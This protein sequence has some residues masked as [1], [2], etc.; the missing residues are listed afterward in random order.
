VVAGQDIGVG[1]WRFLDAFTVPGREAAL[2]QIERFQSDGKTAVVVARFAEP[3]TAHVLGVIAVA[4]VLR[5]DAAQAVRELKAVGVERVVM[6]TGDHATVARAIGQQA[7]VDEVFADL[8]PED[9]LRII[10]ELREQSGPV[11]M[12]GDGVNDAPAL[13][14]ATIGIAMGAAGTD[15][16]LETADIVLMADDLR[17]IPPHAPL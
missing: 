7:G 12:V 5:R 6:L 17:N 8:L 4:D 2:Q 16:A 1:S 11:A 15:V 13:A 9:K 10:K 14:M 3:R